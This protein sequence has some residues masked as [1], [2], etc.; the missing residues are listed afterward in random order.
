MAGTADD[1]RARA[2]DSDAAPDATRDPPSGLRVTLRTFWRLVVVVRVFFPLFFA[3]ARDRRRFLLFGGSRRVDA[4]TRV[5]RATYLRDALVDLGPAFIKLGQILST[6]PDVLPGEYVEVL[7]TL[8]DKVPPDDWETVRPRLESAFGPVEESFDDFDTEPISGASLGQ[9]YT[10]TYEGQ[11]VAVKVLRPGIRRVVEADLRVMRTLMPLLLFFAHEGQR[12]TLENLADDFTQTIREEMDY[13]HEAAMLRGIAANFEDHPKIRVPDTVPE[14]STRNVLTMEY[15]EGTKIDDVAALDEMGVDREELVYRLENA[16][17]QMIL[18]DGVFHADPHPGNLAVQSDG[19]IVFY[20]FGMTGHVDAR[21]RE[22]M[23][24]FYVGIARDDIDRVIDAFV[25]M[26]AL[27]PAADRQLMREAFRVV[28]ETFRG[29]DVDQYRIQQLVSEFQETLYDFPLR[30]PPNLAL[31]VRVSTVLEGVCRTLYPDVDFIQ[32][33]TDYVRERG[34][35]DE[36]GESMA[37][38][39]ARDTV[40]DA[41]RQVRRTTEALLTVPPKL[42]RVLDSVEREDVTVNVVLDDHDDEVFTR[43]AYKV[44]SGILLASNLLAVTLLYAFH[45]ELT[46]GVVALGVLPLGFLLYRAFRTRRGF[47]VRGRPQFTRQGLREKRGDL[48]RPDVGRR[49]EGGE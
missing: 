5:D 25:A 27:D 32:I 17:I 42:D 49:D 33:I 8:Q 22:Q 10:A 24:D 40:E 30:L 21:T 35:E 1:E 19:T 29:R 45:D 38:R 36:A 4:A 6:R 34:V 46:A 2:A 43:F 23:Y 7:S 28:I 11:D 9:V 26:D 16:Y 39:F 15:V 47:R 12:F 48:D 31:V 37:E 41:G 18:E 14:R 3:Y 20:D 44:V 13:D